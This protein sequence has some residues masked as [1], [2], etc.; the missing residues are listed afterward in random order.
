MVQTDAGRIVFLFGHGLEHDG[1]V[2]PADEASDAD[3][4]ELDAIVESMV[5]EP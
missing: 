5:I 2:D 3:I 4:A 1:K